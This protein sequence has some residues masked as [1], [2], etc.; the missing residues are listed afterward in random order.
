MWQPFLSFIINFRY[1]SYLSVWLA[2]LAYFVQ[3]IYIFLNPSL[4]FF[5]PNFSKPLQMTFP[6]FQINTHVF[7]VFFF[8]CFCF[9]YSIFENSI[10]VAKFSKIHHN[11]FANFNIILLHFS[12]I[13][14]YSFKIKLILSRLL[15]IN[16]LSWALQ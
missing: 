10:L 8:Y 11:H 13:L 9:S 7:M 15:V 12:F 16:L 14:F 5:I 6:Q 1:M 2:E 3:Y 4:S